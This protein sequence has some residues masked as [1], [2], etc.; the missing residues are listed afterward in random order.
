MT[1]E[2]KKKLE[3]HLP[4]IGFAELYNKC[5][6]ILA[7]LNEYQEQSSKR[8]T[9]KGIEFGN[10]KFGHFISLDGLTD[11]QQKQV[12]ENNEWQLFYKSFAEKFN[13]ID[14]NNVLQIG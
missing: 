3:C 9:E 5:E 2:L 7:I 4:F 11:E 14:K 13:I 1:D 10:M 8:L 6:Q 12:L